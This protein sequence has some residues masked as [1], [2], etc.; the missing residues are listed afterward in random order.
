MFTIFINSSIKQYGPYG[1]SLLT[2]GGEY[3]ISLKQ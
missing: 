2:R 3:S 1:V